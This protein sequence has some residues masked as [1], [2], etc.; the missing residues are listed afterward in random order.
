MGG[1]SILTGNASLGHL[2]TAFREEIAHHSFENDAF[3]ILPDHLHC[4]WIMP[5]DDTRYSMRWSA[6]KGRFT[7]LFL[8]GGGTETRRSD[9]RRKRSERGVWQA[10]YWEHR[11]RDESDWLRHRDYIHLNPVKHGL[12]SEPRD[13]QW[14]SFHRHV[15]LGW[16]DP[17]WPGASPV[18]LPDVA[19]E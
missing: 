12:A 8:S 4:L 2:R 17:N 7:K 11:I 13:G 9:S 14:T 3:V 18:D 10:R 1:P 16:L 15:Q 6:V 19:G 5:L